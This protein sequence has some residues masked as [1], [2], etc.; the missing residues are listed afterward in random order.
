[1]NTPFGYGRSNKAGYKQS[2]K[3]K[4][5]GEKSNGIN[6]LRPFFPRFLLV[7]DFTHARFDATSQLLDEPRVVGFPAFKFANDL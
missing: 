6:F 1:M 2:D 3:V 4:W 7:D 5:G